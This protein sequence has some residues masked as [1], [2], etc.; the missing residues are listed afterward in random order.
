[1]TLT[2]QAFINF[3][4]NQFYLGKIKV[5][6]TNDE[7][8]SVITGL[9]EPLISEHVYM[10]VQ[11]VLQGK[12][13][14]YKGQTKHEEIPLMGLII[15]PIC[16]RTLTGSAP[17]GNG[18]RYYYYHCQRK[19]GC[20]FSYSAVNANSIFIDY[21]KTFE[22]K[23]EVLTL[24]DKILEKTFQSHY[25]E[26]EIEKMTLEKQISELDRR[27]TLVEEKYFDRHINDVEF[28]RYKD[29]FD[30]EKSELVMKHIS[31][32]K[33]PS[34][35]SKYMRFSYTLLG[36]LSQY[37]KFA[38]LDIKKKIIG[39]IFPEKLRFE[40]DSYRTTKLNQAFALISLSIKDINKKKAGSY[41]S[42]STVAPPSGLEPETP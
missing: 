2:K 37:Y 4:K 27:I 40:N 11:T 18:G 31:I 5:P 1:M 39:S 28:R 34:E 19:Y 38:S 30:S 12:K 35:Y 20:K 13:K 33:M 17:K 3:L 23:K 6:E 15:C 9:H 32:K 26:L 24:Y 36:N 21:L 29:R 10:K 25:K 41:S 8:A 7:A 14:P 22:I 16:S 42:L